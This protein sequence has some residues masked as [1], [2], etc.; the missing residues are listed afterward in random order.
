VGLTETVIV[1]PDGARIAHGATC[2]EP[3]RLMAKGHLRSVF[4]RAIARRNLLIAETTARE[5][6]EIDLAG[7]L[8]PSRVFLGDK[9]H[10]AYAR[11]W[12]GRL[13]AARP[14]GLAEIDAAVT[15]LRALPAPRAGQ[16]L[17]TLL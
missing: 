13:V 8:E 10:H 2:P 15:A 11:R 17:R 6:G 9:T 16:A 4:H 3:T 12:L 1:A 5:I 14:L 7:A